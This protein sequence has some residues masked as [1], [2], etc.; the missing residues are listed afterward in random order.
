MGIKRDPVHRGSELVWWAL[1]KEAFPPENGQPM[2]SYHLRK[3]C[4]GCSHLR[5][6]AAGVLNVPSGGRG[7]SL[8]S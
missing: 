2:L 4:L 3:V 5:Y 8:Q 7:T 1:H 6:E